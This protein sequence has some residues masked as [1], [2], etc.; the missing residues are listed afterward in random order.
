M[1]KS[2]ISPRPTP[3]VWREWLLRAVEVWRDE[4]KSEVAV[5]AGEEV[6]WRLTS[7]M[8]ALDGLPEEPTLDEAAEALRAVLDA[9]E[10]DENWPRGSKGKGCGKN[11]EDFL[12]MPNSSPPSCRIKT[13]AT[14]WR[15]TGNGRGR[16]CPR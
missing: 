4:G 12:T 15:K 13:A 2:S 6:H 3:N 1:S 10:D 11:L 9:D 14:R 7:I 8:A 16:T 5:F